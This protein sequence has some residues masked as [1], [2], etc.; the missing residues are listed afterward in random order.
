MSEP[1]PYDFLSRLKADDRKALQKLF[2][3]HY[4]MVCQA[5]YRMVPDRAQ[6]ED[7]GQEVFIK[8][9]EKRHQLNIQSSIGAYLRR[10]AV[11]EGIS[12][13]RKQKR[14]ES[15]ELNPSIHGGKDNSLETVMAGKELQQRIHQAVGSLPPKCRMVFQLSRQEELSY[16]EIADKLG[17]SIKT[18]ENQMG[19][20]LK[21]LRQLL[22]DDLHCG[23]ILLF[24]LFQ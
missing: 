15:E 23:G 3:Q 2:H 1:T 19:K 24:W 18:V 16:R 17:I 11:N 6:A 7:I 12:Y 21:T 8:L 22:K 13:L 10:M 9:W 4:N 5:V 20:A 14:Y